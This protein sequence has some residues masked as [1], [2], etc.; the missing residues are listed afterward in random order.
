[1]KDCSWTLLEETLS[2]AKSLQLQQ[3][4]IKFLASIILENHIALGYL[5]AEQE[6]ICIFINKSCYA[7]VNN[8]GEIETRLHFIPLKMQTDLEK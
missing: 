6:R 2:T 5:L 8:L 3:K 7:Y 4:S 1:M